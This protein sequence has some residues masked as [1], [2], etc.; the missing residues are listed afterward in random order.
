MGHGA[1]ESEELHIIPIAFVATAIFAKGTLCIYCFIFRRYPSVHVFFIDHRNDIIVN[2][3]GLAMSIVGSRVVWYLDPI[4]AILI[5][6]L[7]LVSWAA[8]AFEHVW[9]LV[10]KSA[11]KEYIS[12]L[13]YLV[14]N[15][16]SRIK[17]VETCRAYHAG[18]KYYVEV[19]VVMDEDL[20][21]KITHDVSQTLQ[22]KLEG[23][24]DVER[25]YVHVDYEHDHDIKEEHKPLYEVLKVDP[26]R[27]ASKPFNSS[28]K[29]RTHPTPSDC[30]VR[31]GTV[32]RGRHVCYAA[33]MFVASKSNV[34]LLIVLIR[35]RDLRSVHI[36]AVGLFP[37][38]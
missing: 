1:S 12:K 14:L 34:C 28:S 5:G 13:V 27:S 2:A 22:R 37:T 35:V 11:P 30:T 15:H 31:S 24:A 20:P 23:L 21:L 25:A 36:P 32:Q 3:F 7:I 19:D 8:N 17:Q 9:L 16:D 6:V 26:L 38:R 33:V 18:Q 4:G 29:R 10:G